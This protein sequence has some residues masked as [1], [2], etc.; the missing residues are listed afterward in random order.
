[1]EGTVQGK[2]KR[3]NGIKN[4]FMRKVGFVING[5]RNLRST[6]ALLQILQINY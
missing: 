5:D 1:M 6:S 4:N 2:K 3:N